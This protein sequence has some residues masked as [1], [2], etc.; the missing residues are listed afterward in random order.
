[1]PAGSLQISIRRA[2]AAPAPPTLVDPLLVLFRTVEDAATVLEQ[3]EQAFSVAY[4]L[5]RRSH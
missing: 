1:M 4:I 5:D 2:P 3:A